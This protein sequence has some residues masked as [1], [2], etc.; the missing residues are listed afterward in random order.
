MAPG[1]EVTL[2]LLAVLCPL[3]FPLALEQLLTAF[4]MLLSPQPLCTHSCCN[5]KQQP[6]GQ[7]I[8]PETL[9]CLVLVAVKYNLGPV[10]NEQPCS[11]LQTEPA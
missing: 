3:M 7:V 8:I 10:C 5:L 2:S 4:S 11:T 6:V 1:T 9:V